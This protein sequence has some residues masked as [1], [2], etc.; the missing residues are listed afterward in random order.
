MCDSDTLADLIGTPVIATYADLITS[1]ALRETLENEFPDS[2][3]IY[4][5]RGAGDPGGIASWVDYE[6][7]DYTQAQLRSEVAGLNDNHADYPTVYSDLSNVPAVKDACDGLTYYHWI[8]WWGH[9]DVPAYPD[10]AI[11]FASAG[12]LGAHLDLSLIRDDNWNPGPQNAPWLAPVVT[13]LRT[14]ISD[15]NQVT[16]SLAHHV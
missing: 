2:R 6:N 15:L 5:A 1:A 13:A 3:I 16:A 9:I 11:Q 8:A 14:T 4:G 12:T 10:A 7:G